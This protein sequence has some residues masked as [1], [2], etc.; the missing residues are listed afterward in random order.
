[1]KIYSIIFLISAFILTAC[2]S[3]QPANT[4]ANTAQTQPQTA[5]NLE[6]LTPTQVLKEFFEASKRKDIATV[7][8]S[9]SKNS[10]PLIEKNAELINVSVDEYLRET[11]A[12][13]VENDVETR[14]EKISGETATVEF[15]DTSMEEYGS[16]PFVKEEGIWK[17]ALDKLA[18]QMQKALTE[19]MN[20]PATKES[21][22]NK[23]VKK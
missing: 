7:K 9:L 18:E 21:N 22:T 17:L 5:K 13:R 14:N 15:K 4:T 12:I 10:F 16:L 8:K 6:S 11:S 23:S 3:S 2:S 20:A 19:Q 1:M